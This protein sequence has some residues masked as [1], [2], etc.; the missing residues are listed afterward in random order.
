MDPITQQVV[1]AS[2]GAAGADDATYVD[3]VFSTTVYTGNSSGTGSG[4]EQIITTGIDNTEKSLIWFKN[5]SASS[6]HALFDTERTSPDYRWIRTSSSGAELQSAAVLKDRTTTGFTVVH[7]T[8]GSGVATTNPSDS[9]KM[10]SWNFRA[11][12]GFFDVVT[13]SGSNST[14]AIAHSLGS[15]PGMIL[16]KRLDSTASWHVFHENISIDDHLRLDTDAATNSQDVFNSTEPTSTHFTV[17]GN[18]SGVNQ[19]NGQ[20]V[21]Y[22]FANDDARF[23]TNSDES[24]IKCG[25]YAGLGGGNTVDIDLGFES[26]WVMIKNTSV[27]SNWTVVDVMRGSN[28]EDGKELHPNRD[29]AE[30]DLTSKGIVCPT[31]TGFKVDS[32]S[33]PGNVDVNGSGYTYV[34]MAIRRPHKPLT[35]ASDVFAIDTFTSGDPNYTSGFPVD[36]FIRRPSLSVSGN[37]AEAGARLLG[38]QFFKTNEDENP[39]GS[40]SDVY[41]YMNGFADDTGSTTTDKIAWMFRRAP[42]FMDV[43]SFDYPSSS[44]AI[45]HNLGVAPELIIHKPFSNDQHWLVGSDYLSNTSGWNK[46]LSLNLSDSESATSTVWNQTAPTTTNF[47]LG[48]FPGTTSSGDS[49]TGIAFLFATLSGISKVGSY[50]GTGNDVDVDCGFTA[51]ARFVLIKRIEFAGSWYLWDTTRGIVSGNDPYILLDTTAAQVTDQDYIDPINSGFRVVSN[52]GA[53]NAT[54]STYLFLAIA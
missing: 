11:M 14:Q 7:P 43:V 23:G 29:Y 32:P 37:E 45:S 17:I 15:K 50:A 33:S 30:T 4:D 1:L 28:V 10:I 44:S 16:I 24:I 22:L 54:G 53:L 12:P 31:S 41:D 3:D 42:G 2:A 20:Y 40:P 38:A 19:L 36:A 27:A 35:A 9:E 52:I 48:S 46:Y 13:Y 47:T 8:S 39:V 49:Y 18:N 21:A 5:R 26:Q 25:T 34:Y 6:D 51:G